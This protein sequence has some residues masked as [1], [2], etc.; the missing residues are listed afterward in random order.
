MRKNRY[1]SPDAVILAYIASNSL[2]D[3]DTICRDLLV[4]RQQV[5]A[6]V[7]RL[8]ADDLVRELK[9]NTYPRWRYVYELASS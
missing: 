7:K 5:R 4:S 9:Q 2:C 8:V 1:A 6:S 3:T